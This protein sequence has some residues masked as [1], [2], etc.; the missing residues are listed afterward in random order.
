M[1]NIYKLLLGVFLMFSATSCGEDFL[2]TY[3][4][5]AVDTGAVF[6][7]TENAWGALNGIH[8][9]LYIRYQ[10]DQD[11][12]GQSAI[13]MISDLAGE[14]CYM[15]A[16]TNRYMTVTRWTA[17]ESDSNRAI[18]FAWQ[19]Y[20]KVIANANLIIGNIDKAVGPQADKNAIKGQALA[21]RGW[22]HFMLVQLYGMRYTNGVENSQLGVPIMTFENSSAKARNTVEEVYTLVNSDLDKAIELLEG[23]KRVNK[24]H[25]DQTVAQA[26]KARVLLTQ[27]HWLEAAQMA[28]KVIDSK[29]YSFMSHDQHFEGYNDYSNPEW[30]WSSKLQA[31]Q[32]GNVFDNFFAYMGYNFNGRGT[33]EGPRCINKLLYDKISNTDIR[34]NKLWVKDSDTDPSVVYTGLRPKYMHQKFRSSSENSAADCCVPYMRVP[35]MYLT[36]AEGYA[37]AGGEYTDKARELLYNVLSTR[38]PQYKK[39]TKSGDALVDEI[40]TTRR[41]ELWGEGFRF[42]DLKRLAQKLDR[43]GTGV[44]TTVASVMSV[45]AGDSRWQWQIPLVEIRA[46]PL[47][48]QNP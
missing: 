23:Y 7:T 42:F 11:S 36:A 39:S 44:S 16:S 26:F 47:I 41:I 45:E 46:N 33:R 35:E 24:S 38:D 4:T 32:L 9:L 13:M 2:E 28:Q 5:N 29:S 8:R 15:A 14:D 48:I 27:G 21:Y 10:S 22:A 12:Y 19:Y 31:D 3:P 43:N 30:M 1:K 37:K 18:I 6:S 34:K 40:L 20:Y 25:I 17:F